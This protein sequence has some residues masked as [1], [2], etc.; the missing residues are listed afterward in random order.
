[1]LAIKAPAEYADKGA[2]GQAMLERLAQDAQ[3]QIDALIDLI[4]AR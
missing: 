1:M 3:R 4:E 2:R